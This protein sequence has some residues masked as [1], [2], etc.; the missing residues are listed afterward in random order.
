MVSTSI[1]TTVFAESLTTLQLV[2]FVLLSLQYSLS[3]L[4]LISAIGPYSLTCPLMACSFFRLLS[5]H[6]PRSA[7]TCLRVNAGNR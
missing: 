6:G 5:V 1:N 4:L 3:C 2:S 7:K